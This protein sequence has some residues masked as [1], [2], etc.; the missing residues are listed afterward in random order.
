LGNCV[1]GESELESK[2]GRKRRYLDHHA[3]VV[4]PR[5][6]DFIGWAYY[7]IHAEGITWR[8]KRGED[9]R[10]EERREERKGRGGRRERGEREKNRE[11]VKSGELR[12]VAWAY[13]TRGWNATIQMTLGNSIQRIT[14]LSPSSIPFSLRTSLLFSHL[15]SWLGRCSVGG[16]W[17]LRRKT[18]S[19]G[20]RERGKETRERGETGGEG[21]WW[22]RR[23]GR[24]E[25][26]KGEEEVSEYE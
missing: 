26:G 15:W 10:G 25:K 21:R 13:E 9:R 6:I 24:G 8:E 5:E 23:G 2:N 20:S 11:E 4:S 7:D 17:S 18:S 19:S 12:K 1:E 14:L 16:S 3:A 22:E